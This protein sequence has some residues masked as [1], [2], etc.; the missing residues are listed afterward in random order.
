MRLDSRTNL[1]SSESSLN[2][3]ASKRLMSVL[4]AEGQQGDFLFSA[5]DKRFNLGLFKGVSGIGY[6]ILRRLE[7]SLPNVLLLE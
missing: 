4:I 7:M 1:Q 5:G 2:G 6:T 3:E